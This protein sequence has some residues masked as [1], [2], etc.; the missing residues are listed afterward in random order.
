MKALQTLKSMAVV[1]ILSLALPALNISSAAANPSTG[2]AQ[3]VQRSE[4]E[5]VS[6]NNQ[7]EYRV[8]STLTY[9]RRVKTKGSRLLVRSTPGGRVIGYL[10][11]GTYVR[12][13]DRGVNGWVRIVAPIRGYVSANYLTYCR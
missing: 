3:N 12:I 1:A 7:T 4:G 2:F 9:C 6:L 13:S 5:L 11:N 8:A 10:R